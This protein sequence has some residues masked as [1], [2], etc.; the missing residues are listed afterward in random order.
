MEARI[1]KWGNSLGLRI[2]R[3]LAADIGL[4][5]DVAVD[6]RIQS[7]QLVIVPKTKKYELDELL[8]QIKPT[9][10]HNQTD[11]GLPVGKELW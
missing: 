2:P 5:E 10:V 1:K 4:Q 8:A 11:W 9:N 7:G 3:S 6:L